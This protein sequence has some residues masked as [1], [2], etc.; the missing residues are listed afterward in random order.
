M[1][2]I[3]HIL[4]LLLLMLVMLG[5]TNF[6]KA[7][8]LNYNP[9]KEKNWWVMPSIGN[10][11]HNLHH[12]LYTA[13]WGSDVHADTEVQNLYLGISYGHVLAK[14]DKKEYHIDIGYSYLGSTKYQLSHPKP[15]FAHWLPIETLTVTAWE[16]SLLFYYGKRKHGRPYMFRIGYAFPDV[17]NTIIHADNSIETD[18]K[19]YSEA[20]PLLGFGI[21]Y[22]NIMLEY[23]LYMISYGSES[24]LFEKQQ[25]D[26][27]NGSNVVLIGYRF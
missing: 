16:S 20:G 2:K 11:S 23:R 5:F 4:K 26:F 15:E 18:D 25:G 13:R 6:S 1:I 19:F 22:K 9:P 7:E 12:E 21:R 24:L 10:I 14:S 27:S 3:S 17:D 8:V